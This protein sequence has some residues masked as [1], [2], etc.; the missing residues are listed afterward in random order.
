VPSDRNVT[1]DMLQ[2]CCLGHPG[3]NLILRAPRSPVGRPTKYK[4]Y[5][6]D[7]FIITSYR[8]LS[9]CHINCYT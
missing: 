8:E 4:V 2:Y 1:P 6:H 3:K 5:Y 9:E 7:R